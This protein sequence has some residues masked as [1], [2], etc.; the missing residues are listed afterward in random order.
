[1]LDLTNSSIKINPDREQSFKEGKKMSLLRLLGIA[2]VAVGIGVHVYVARKVPSFRWVI[3]SAALLEAIGV[4][5]L[6]TL[7]GS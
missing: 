1:M 7:R 4:T 3:V 5:I 2:L 6:A